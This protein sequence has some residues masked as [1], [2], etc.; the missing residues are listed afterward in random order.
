M[1][2]F[3]QMFRFTWALIMLIV[4]VACEGQQEFVIVDQREVLGEVFTEQTGNID[5]SNSSADLFQDISARRQ[6][7]H[8][9]DLRLN[10]SARLDRRDVEERILETYDLPGAQ[11]DK[12]CIIP[13]D[14]PAGKIYQYEIEWTQVNREGNIEEGQVA[15]QGNILGTYSIVVDLQCQVVG[16]TTIR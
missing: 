11:G 12:L 10:E 2:T 3:K 6:F 9:I 13:A 1:L 16:V 5:N 8:S 4:L 7:R 14:V 15:G